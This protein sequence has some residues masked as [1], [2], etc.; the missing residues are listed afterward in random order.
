[1][2]KLYECR[3]LEDFK[4]LDKHTQ[5]EI[6]SMKKPLLRNN[7][8]L[9]KNTVFTR[10]LTFDLPRKITCPYMPKECEHCY[11][12][13]VEQM[14]E[15]IGMDSQIR[16]FRKENLIRSLNSEFVS[17]MTNEIMRKRLKS[18]QKL[19]VRIHSSGDF[20]DMQYLLKWVEIALTVRKESKDPKRISFVA[21][22]K[23]YKY[24]FDLLEY[25]NHKIAEIYKR[26][27]G[28][29]EKERYSICDLEIKFLISRMDSSDL[30]CESYQYATRKLW[31]PVY[32]ATAN[33]ADNIV[34]CKSMDCV[35][36][37]KCYSSKESVT[38][39]LRR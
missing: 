17:K 28:S 38:T 39:I 31:L 34:D 21:Y 20:Y 14:H 4:N 9:G 7:R 29:C 15:G 22:T 6:F 8:F 12:S 16:T 32:F 3:K 2:Q 24:I 10:I 1:M 33:K 13:E 11:Q 23:A 27:N 26:I 19:F 25:E 30:Y 37:L 35:S 5:D 36:C 18:G